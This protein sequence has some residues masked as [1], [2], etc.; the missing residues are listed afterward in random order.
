MSHMPNHAKSSTAWP[1]VLSLLVHLARSVG[2]PFMCLV[3]SVAQVHRCKFSLKKLPQMKLTPDSI[4]FE[5]YSSII[6]I[7]AICFFYP[8]SV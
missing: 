5:Q 2:Y 1:R 6:K 7:R 8:G 4:Q 3:E